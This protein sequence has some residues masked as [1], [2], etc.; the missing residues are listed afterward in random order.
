MEPGKESNTVAVADAE[1]DQLKADLRR[2]HE[3]YLRALADFENYRRRVGRD[4]AKSSASGKRDV[5]LSLLEVLDSCVMP[6]THPL[7][8]RHAKTD[9]QQPC[10]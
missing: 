4:Q 10:L 3:M 1:L 2:E 8:G 6:K 7:A 5:L 9:E